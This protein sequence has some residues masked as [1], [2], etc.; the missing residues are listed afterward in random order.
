MTVLA[1]VVGF[2]HPL[3]GFDN[4]ALVRV[5]T[6]LH[7]GRYARHQT[8]YDLRRLNRQGRILRLP[9]HHR[10]QLTPPGRR[11]ALLSTKVYGR[12]LAPVWPS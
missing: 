3:V 7:G 9:G 1:A 6:A 10:Y 11:V 5:V 12:V 4:P 2:I 8:T